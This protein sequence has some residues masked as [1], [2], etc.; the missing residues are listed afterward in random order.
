MLLEI[1]GRPLLSYLLGYLGE[2]GVKRVV[3]T[4]SHLAEQVEEYA[5]DYVGTPELEVVVE[6]DALGTAGAMAD[7]LPLFPHEPILVFYGDVIAS[8]DLRPL[9]D[10]HAQHGPVASLAVYYR[11]QTQAKGVVDLDGTLITGFHEK[12][13]SRTEG[14]VN[15]GIY[16]VEPDWVA[17]YRDRPPPLDF[18]YDLFPAAL[19]AGEELRA[20]RLDSPVLDIGTEADLAEARER[21]LPKLSR[22]LRAPRERGRANRRRA[23]QG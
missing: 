12:D 20:H 1:D 15:G 13:P 8:Q 2:H 11:K 18:G 22:E 7:A 23:A 21:G 6:H 5:R 9:A 10:L 19:E 17:S 16:I 14:W 4:A 3:V